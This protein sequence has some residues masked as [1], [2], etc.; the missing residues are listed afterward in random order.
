MT[1][2]DRGVA[3][4]GRAL[5]A[6]DAAGPALV[7]E[8]PLSLWGGMDPHT[9]RLTDHHHPQLGATI[10][11]RVLVMPSGRGSS[12]SSSVLAEAI[13][14]GTAP[15]AILLS[16]PD[17]ILV[18]GALV[19]DY[20]YGR[21]CPVLVLP[22]GLADPVTT[23]DR[24]ELHGDRIMLVRATATRATAGRPRARPAGSRDPGGHDPDPGSPSHGRDPGHAGPVRGP[25]EEPGRP[26]G[27]ASR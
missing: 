19:A 4:Q 5:V 21:T 12:S 14:L 7:L 17:E 22:D 24:V 2:S 13:R 16:E 25:S 26:A 27:E 9:G 3:L 10:T 15:V 8:A 6:G 1:R 23:G 20:L 18:L 11:G